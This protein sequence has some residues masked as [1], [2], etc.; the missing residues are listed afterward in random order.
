MIWKVRGRNERNSAI[1]WKSENSDRTFACEG[2]ENTTMGKGK[3]R[4]NPSRRRLLKSAGAVAA[5][6]LIGCASMNFSAS[7]KKTAERSTGLTLAVA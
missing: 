4:T 7:S 3:T 2:K 6:G 1:G 5:G